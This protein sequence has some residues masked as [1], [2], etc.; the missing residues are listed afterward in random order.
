MLLNIILEVDNI[1]YFIKFE[2]HTIEPFHILIVSAVQGISKIYSDEEYYLSPNQICRTPL[3]HYTP[4][5][6]LSKAI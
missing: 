1:V 4:Y 3:S 6:Y 2:I 5:M